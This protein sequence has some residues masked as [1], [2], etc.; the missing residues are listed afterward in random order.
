MKKKTITVILITVS[1]L[2]LF[3]SCFNQDTTSKF[4]SSDTTKIAA[5]DKFV[6]G[7]SIA[8][9]NIVKDKPRDQP[10][11]YN[12]VDACI[13]RYQKI[14]SDPITNAQ[15]IKSAYTESMQFGSYNLGVWLASLKNVTNTTQIRISL[16][17]YTGQI[18]PNLGATEDRLTAFL[19]PV[20][21]SNRPA[22]YLVATPTA[23]GVTAPAGA[24]VDPYD[25]A[26]LKP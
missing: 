9:H 3:E 6:G 15:L 1:G 24:P 21:A 14:Y 2:L 10:V 26:G 4:K 12:D 5:W 8:F 16:G 19:C 13:K 7:D 18:V 25:L 20:D 17:M 11:P 23:Q 22:V